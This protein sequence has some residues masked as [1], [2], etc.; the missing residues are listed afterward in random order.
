MP[1][2]CEN[3][4]VITGEA[5]QVEEVR[6][7]MTKKGRAGFHFSAMILEPRLL[8]DEAWQEW[9]NANWGD[10]EDGTFEYA[11]LEYVPGKWRLRFTTAWSVPTPIY[12]RLADTYRGVRVEFVASDSTGGWLKKGHARWRHL[13]PGDDGH[14]ELVQDTVGWD[15]KGTEDGSVW[16]STDRVPDGFWLSMEDRKFVTSSTCRDLA[17]EQVIQTGHPSG[18]VAVRRLRSGWTLKVAEAKSIALSDLQ[19]DLVC[20]YSGG[21]VG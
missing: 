6:R 17:F 1:N 19:F 8:H 2:F 3:S 14:V 7:R 15:G 18:L 21:L 20:M 12:Q 10:K 4:V 13:K 11:D 16:F 9:R 5:G